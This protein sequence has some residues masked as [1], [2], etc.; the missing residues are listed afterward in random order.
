MPP[1][2]KFLAQSLSKTL[3][4]LLFQ[5]YTKSFKG[6][7]CSYLVTEWRFVHIKEGY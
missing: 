5:S 2:N 6:C 1:K 3:Y 4:V 7:C